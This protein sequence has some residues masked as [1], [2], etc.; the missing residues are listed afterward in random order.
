MPIGN[1][2][3]GMNVW[4]EENGDLFMLVSR[5]DAW[6]EACRLLKVGRVRVRLTPNPFTKGLPFRQ[7]LVLH[8]GKIVIKAADMTLTLSMVPTSGS[9]I[10]IACLEG[11]GKT[12]RRLE[13]GFDVWRNTRRELKGEELGS[14]WTMKDS[15]FPVWESADILTSGRSWMM[16]RHENESSVAPFTLKH[17]SLDQFAN[18]VQDPMAGRTF[19]MI[20]GSPDTGLYRSEGVLALRE[21]NFK[22]N[23]ASFATKRPIE[24]LQIALE[25][26]TKVKSVD[27]ACAAWWKKFWDRSYIF[28]R[29]EDQLTIPSTTHKLRVGADS[30]GGNLFRGSMKE[31]VYFDRA[32]TPKELANLAASGHSST[33]GLPAT[34]ATFKPVRDVKKDGDDF[35]FLDGYLEAE[36]AAHT[37]KGFTAA[38]WI[39]QSS[40][41]PVGRIFDRL[42]AGQAD[43]WLFDTHPGRSLR[44]I[45]GSTEISAPNIVKPEEWTHV[46]AVVDPQRGAF[47]Y[48]NGL[49]VA[50]RA[51]DSSRSP[52]TSAYVLQRYITACGG[53]GQFPIKFNGS[54]FTVEP[55]DLG[56]NQNPDWRR[57]GGDYWW[58]NTRLPYASMV[59]SGDPEMLNSLFR[60]YE[61]VVPICEARAKSYHGVR[62]A[63]FPE[64]MNIFGLYSNSDYGWKRDG[65]AANVVQ[66]PW[67]MYAWNQGPELVMLMLDYFDAT[68]DQAFCRER[69]WPMADSVLAYFESRF[70]EGG[71][72]RISPTQAVETYWEDVVNDTPTV[73]GLHSIVDRLVRVPGADME[74]LR[75]LKAS[76]PAIPIKDGKIA[77]AES[78]S[79]KRSNVENPETYAIWPFRL[80][81]VG[82][83]DL[84][85]A[86]KT[87]RERIERSNSGWQYEGQQAATL[88]LTEDAKASLLS[89]VQNSNSKY[90]WPATWGPNYDWLPDQCHGGNIMT[91]LQTMVLQ[92]VGD[93]LYVLPAWPSE[94]DVK[95]RL[96]ASR[97]TVVTAE[98]RKGKLISV[99]VTP[100]SRQVDVVLGDGLNP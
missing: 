83:P 50:S 21:S 80:Y 46:T 17:Q 43:G 9:G 64:T 92:E 52:I 56:F 68:G 62:G 51:V 23:I 41:N 15:P 60:M 74:R 12:V 29:G 22:V 87:F 97:A 5:T 76:L 88:G 91:T 55:T 44:L 47:I 30:S 67:W 45:V 6:S 72:M 18:L 100:K 24:E 75:K 90:R 54:I 34:T 35:K 79:P 27:K 59:A 42:T 71:K 31:P 14:S 3:M 98:Y 10:D 85:M 32:L 11:K 2:E 28:V 36:A 1:G 8:D 96:H 84:E 38:A 7:E 37:P 70:T 19:G 93:K 58:Q 25:G 78:F 33:R 65:I 69:L 40:Q 66:S 89:K 20:V 4:V 49:L 82:R 73:A 61:A 48:R 63:Y 81:G 77:A 57:W 95:F 26:A 53:R 39:Y 13:V 86:R 99:A 16:V 94:W